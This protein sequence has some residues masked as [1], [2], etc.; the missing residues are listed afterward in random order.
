MTPQDE[1]L[2]RRSLSAHT[3]PPPAIVLVA[4]DDGGN[5]PMVQFC[6]RLKTLAPNLKIKKESEAIFPAPALIT[7]RHMNIGYQA[8][9]TGKILERM[10]DAINSTSS[11]VAEAA[12]PLDDR[13]GQIDLPAPLKLYVAEQ[14]PHCPQVL[15]QLQA[16]AAQSPLI[17]LRVI[18]AQAFERQARDD[19]VRSVP[20]LILDDQVRWTG[21]VKIEEVLTL[22]LKRDPTR[23]SAATIRQL[24]EAGDAGRVSG[25]MVESGKL[26]PALTELLTHDRWSVRLGAMVTAEYLAEDAP[27]LALELCKLLWQQFDKL[28]AQVQGDVLQVLGQIQ[29]DVTRGYLLKVVSGAYDEQTRATAAEVLDEMAKTGD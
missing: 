15:V 26:F 11:G 8:V 25:M 27:D 6:N 21:P 14:C 19:Q 20:T 17:R 18:D 24:I 13:V 2:I 12:P 22:C 5:D 16:L 3:D 1:Q 23:L 10:L 7:G 29:S 28:P 4:G 9:P